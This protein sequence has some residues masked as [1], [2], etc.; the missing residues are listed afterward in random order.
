M[1]TETSFE[2]YV[3][4]YYGGTLGISKRYG[5]AK[6]DDNMTTANDQYFNVMFGA[7]VFNQLN[8]KSEVFKLLNKAGW[9]QSGW[10][11]LT[12]RHANTVGKAEGDALGTTDHPESKK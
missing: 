10:R 1:S 8:T 11:V 12:Q 6:S 4:A 5:I 2:E 7:S 3:N 9:T